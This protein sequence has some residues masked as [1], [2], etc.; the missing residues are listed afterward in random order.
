MWIFKEEDIHGPERAVLLLAMIYKEMSSSELLHKE[1][2]YF[3]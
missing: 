2:Y 1:T 3:H